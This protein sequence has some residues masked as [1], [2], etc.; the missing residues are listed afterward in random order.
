M[1]RRY[2]ADEEKRDEFPVLRSVSFPFSAA[3][4]IPLSHEVFTSCKI[5]FEYLVLSDHIL[6]FEH[7]KYYTVK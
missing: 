6:D 4:N 1:R 2:V 7:E 3:N 5:V